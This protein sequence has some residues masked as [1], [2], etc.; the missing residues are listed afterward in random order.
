MGRGRPSGEG[1]VVLTSVREPEAPSPDVGPGDELTN[2]K[3]DLEVVSKIAVRRPKR[4]GQRKNEVN[5]EQALHDMRVPAK[6]KKLLTG[7]LQKL[8]YALDETDVPGRYGRSRRVS[9]V[10]SGDDTRY[11]LYIPSAVLK[12]ED[13]IPE[14]DHLK[15]SFIQVPTIYI[16]SPKRNSFPN[17]YFTLIVKEQWSIRVSFIDWK[18]LKV[19][20]KP[21]FNP[22]L[23]AVAEL[24]EPPLASRPDRGPSSAEHPVEGD[25]EHVAVLPREHA[26]TGFAPRGGGGGVPSAKTPGLN[27]TKPD[28]D[29]IVSELAR[30]TPEGPPDPK[31]HYEYLIPRAGL[32]EDWIQQLSGTWTGNA[33]VDAHSLVDFA[34]S[35]GV[36]P[37]DTKYTALGSL[38][39][40]LFEYQ[41]LDQQYKTAALRRRGP[42]YRPSR[43]ISASCPDP[44]T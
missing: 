17:P 28:K 26:A 42:P 39:T 20:N 44:G 36:N 4:A 18:L 5:P 16:V 43:T 27:L 15:Y 8:S 2:L 19:L 33:R 23:K 32:P 37:S 41:D 24:F 6:V 14:F 1:R 7:L 22:S 12:D 31:H 13:N 10:R 40:T 35:K 9:V 21:K 3:S 25:H 34:L 30:L 11:L 29:W 38:L